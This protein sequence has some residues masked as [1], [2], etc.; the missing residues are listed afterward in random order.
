MSTEPSREHEEEALG[1][2]MVVA[3]IRVQ[4]RLQV[5]SALLKVQRDLR[6]R[7]TLRL[8]REQR[9]QRRS[10]LGDEPWIGAETK[11]FGGS[12]REGMRAT[13]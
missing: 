10:V 9:R 2:E 13:G 6:S 1:G 3:K 4:T 8:R 7:R 5:G 12:D 11:L